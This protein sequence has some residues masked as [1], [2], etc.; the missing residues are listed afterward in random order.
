MCY[1]LPTFTRPGFA[2]QRRGDGIVTRLVR[3]LACLRPSAPARTCPAA[4]H[5]ARAGFRGAV[6]GRVSDESGAVLPGVTVTVTPGHQRHNSTVTNETGAYSLLYL[7]PGAYVV[8]AELQGFKKVARQRRGPRRRSP[9]ARFQDGSRPDRRDGQRRRGDPAARDPQRIGRA[10]HRR[11]AD[12][13]DAAVGR[14][15]VRAGAA[16]ARRRLHRRPEVLAPVRQRRHLRLSPPTAARAATSSRSTAR[17]TWPTAGA[18]RSCRP[19]ARCRSS[20]SRPR[21]STRSRVTPPAPP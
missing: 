8:S 18:S 2:L 5:C 17:R 14:Q 9:R 4:G 7:T 11:E 21:P 15:S 10:G 6:V 12:R 20:R 19:R 13:A 16:G 1:R 3:W